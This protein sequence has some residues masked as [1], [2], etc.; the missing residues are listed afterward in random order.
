MWRFFTGSAFSSLPSNLASKN[1]VTKLA[2]FH[3]HGFLLAIVVFLFFIAQF[4]GRDKLE[5]YFKSKDK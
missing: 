1:Y 4:I 3:M 2:D 5:F